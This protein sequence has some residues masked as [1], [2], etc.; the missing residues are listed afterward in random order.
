MKAE[1]QTGRIQT[2]TDQIYEA[3]K[4][5]D[6]N[7]TQ[8]HAAQTPVPFQDLFL[9]F[10]GALLFSASMNLL[11]VPAGMYNGGFLGIAQ[12]L[13]IV[14]AAPLSVLPI[15]GDLSG[16]I[17]FGLNI[18]LLLFSW[19]RFGRLFFAKTVFCVICYSVLLSLIP[20]LPAP[21]L[22]EKIAL[23]LIGG[24]ACGTGAA[25]TLV[26][27][28]SGG[29]E[30]IL[31]LLLS[32]KDARFSVGRF[33]LL[34]NVFIYGA[35]F[36]IFDYRAVIYSLIFTAVTFITLDRVHLQNVMMTM[37]VI[38]KMPD[39]EQVV[40]DCVHRGVTV[41]EG[42]GGYSG[43]RSEV[44]MTVVSKKE[45]LVLRELLQQHDPNVFIICNEDVSVTGNFQ[46]RI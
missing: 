11:I 24:I 8:N 10:F 4:C 45:A 5:A 39:L 32:Q 1:E 36:L 38:T 22:D 37:T 29:G 15:K 16:L 44:L 30:E 14:A 43:E 18:P 7:S 2:G 34:L 41:W 31:G 26:A 6:Q 9:I 13:R 23:C 27:G 40:F 33:S 46:K 17:Y 21:L 28:C 20:V 25:L 35:G 3:N 42:S 19:H 12:L